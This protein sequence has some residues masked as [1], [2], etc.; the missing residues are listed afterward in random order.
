M[1]LRVNPMS[2]GE[3]V[4]AEREIRL[5]TQRET[6]AELGVSVRTLQGWENED[7]IPWAKH[8]RAIRAWLQNGDGEVAA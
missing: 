6:A 3:A 5:L 7:V 8:R 2:W 1:D 4:R